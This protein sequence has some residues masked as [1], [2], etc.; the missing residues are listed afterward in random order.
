MP[1]VHTERAPHLRCIDPR[2]NLIQGKRETGTGQAQAALARPY[3][4]DSTMR[5]IKRWTS[6]RR[7]GGLATAVALL[8]LA[9]GPVL[10]QGWP[11]EWGWG[12]EPP[13]PREPVYREP[14][15]Q[16]PQGYQGYDSSRSAICLQLEQRLAQEA[17]RGSQARQLLPRIEQEIR[18]ADHQFQSGQAQLERNGCFEYFLFAKSLRRTRQCVD[19]N[20]Q[21]EAARTRLSE[22]EAQRQQLLSSGNR[23][24]REDI[25]RELA[26]NNCGATYQQQAR[27]FNP[28]SSIWQDE[29]SSGFHGG[30]FGNLPIA[31]FR[32]V[33]VRLC[34]GYYFPVSF[35]TLPN[36]FDRDAQICESKCA[37]PAELFYH[38]NPGGSMEDAVSYS[39]RQPY[40]S[41]KTAFRYRKEYVQGCSCKQ[42]EYN[43]EVDQPQKR[44]EAPGRAA[45]TR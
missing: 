26:R 24:Y 38:Q 32:T 17:N 15:P 43:P 40:T 34:D 5:L 10:A 41:L 14:P 7:Y 18:Q 33:S 4:C 27:Q 11:W 44:A 25:I 23:S 6:N 19:L 9:S 2:A 16:Q 42:A 30:H 37:A 12:Q 1:D 21:V 39:T 29:D 3:G 8:L 45:D 22:L 36:H 28:F 13:R 20:R 31:T 35:S